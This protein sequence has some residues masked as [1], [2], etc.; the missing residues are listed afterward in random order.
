MKV[1]LFATRVALGQELRPDL[2]QAPLIAQKTSKLN[3]WQLRFDAAPPI[4]HGIA[5]TTAHWKAL[6]QS[7]LLS[8]RA[9]ESVQDWLHGCQAWIDATH[10]AWGWGGR[11]EISISEYPG[12]RVRTYC[13]LK[14][15]LNAK[16]LY[17]TKKGVTIEEFVCIP[18]YPRNE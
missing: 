14:C 17:F 2:H 4:L 16:N 15:T 1:L 8:R 7:F 3:S 12:T 6:N 10:T 13:K 9:Q 11:R 5:Q 18:Q